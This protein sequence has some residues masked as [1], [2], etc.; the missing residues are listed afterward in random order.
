[1]TVVAQAGW[2]LAHAFP[3]NPTHGRTPEWKLS[4]GWRWWLGKILKMPGSLSPRAV[5]KILQTR[6]PD[7]AFC[8]WLCHLPACELGPVT[9]EAL[10]AIAKG[11]SGSDAE[12]KSGSPLGS[13]CGSPFASRSNS[14]SSFSNA[15]S[16]GLGKGRG[17]SSPCECAQ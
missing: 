11:P 15:R 17:A 16:R 2:N 9:E 6:S 14:P 12:S 5:R 13:S 7:P 4:W 10:E 8:L 3:L 1:M